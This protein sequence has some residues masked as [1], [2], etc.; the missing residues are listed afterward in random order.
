MTKGNLSGAA[1]L[2]PPRPVKRPCPG[3][4]VPQ[5]HAYLANCR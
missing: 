1:A 3:M 5:W 2:L 4:G